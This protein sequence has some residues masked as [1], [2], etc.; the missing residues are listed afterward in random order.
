MPVLP[1]DFFVQVTWVFG[2]TSAPLGA[3]TTLG[4]NMG[5]AFP[6]QDTA[7]AMA[8]I[9]EATML[10]IQVSS[11]TLDEVIV[12]Q[13]PNEDG[14]TGTTAVGLAGTHI[15]SGSSPNTAYLVKKNT[16]LG[17]RRN[18]G[19]F[20]IPG[21]DEDKVDP[22]GSITPAWVATVQGVVDD[23]YDA[24]GAAT[25]LPVVLHERVPGPTQ[26]AP[27]DITSFTLESTVAT[28]RRRLRK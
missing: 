27:T 15:G 6:P 18:R 10:D 4:V 8:A 19:R 16:A 3:V 1:N 5:G 24:F 9:W 13:G 12:R 25:V 17:G 26:P 11:I 23:F 14:P 21:V 7:E 28:Q 22:S 20:Y 2:G